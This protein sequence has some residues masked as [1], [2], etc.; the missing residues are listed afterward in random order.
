MWRR[1]SSWTRWDSRPPRWESLSRSSSWDV[2]CWRPPQ[3]GFPIPLGRG[4]F[5]VFGNGPRIRHRP[6]LDQSA[7]GRARVRSSI[8]AGAAAWPGV[9]SALFEPVV[10]SRHHGLGTR[11][12]GSA[13][14][15]PRW[16]W[17]VTSPSPRALRW[18]GPS[19]PPGRGPICPS[20]ERPGQLLVWRRRKPSDAAFSDTMLAG[21]VLAIAA[22][23]FSLLITDSGPDSP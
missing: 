6:I 15:L 17:A 2:R 8:L 7:N 10:T 23:A 21:V 4:R 16:R 11:T 9:G 13:P 18:R 22:V 5:L 1:F 3:G 14:R 19:S 12:T 20:W